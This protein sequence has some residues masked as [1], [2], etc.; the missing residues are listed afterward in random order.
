M[1]L[2]QRRISLTQRLDLPPPGREFEALSH[3]R[4]WI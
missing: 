4:W 2:Q 1:A 3:L